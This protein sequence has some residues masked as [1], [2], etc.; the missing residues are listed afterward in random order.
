MIKYKKTVTNQELEKSNFKG[1]S[2]FETIY[3][4]YNELGYTVSYTRVPDGIIRTLSNNTT[5][6]Q[7]FINVNDEFFV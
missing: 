6:S 1:L 5:V 4:K 7:V 2:L 3:G